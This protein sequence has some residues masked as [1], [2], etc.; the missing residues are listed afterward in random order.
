[1]HS[2]LVAWL[3]RNTAWL[4]LPTIAVAE[5]VRGVAKLRRA[6][7]E[8]RADAFQDWL[9]AILDLYADRVRPFG[10]RA[11]R[12]TGLLHDRARATGLDPGFADLA[13]AGIAQ[14][15]DL[16]LLTRNLRHFVPLGIAAQDPFAILPA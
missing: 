6:G 16:V 4:F 14:A 3:D 2:A 9:E 1:M 7:A 15:N 10:T 8:G 13:I 12:A 11:A 5:I